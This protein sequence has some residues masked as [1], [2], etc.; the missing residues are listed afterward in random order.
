M[1]DKTISYAVREFTIPAGAT[2][3]AVR[4]AGFVTCLDASRKF[5]ISFDDGTQNDFEAGLTY[6]PK[7]GFTRLAIYNPSDSVLTVRLGLG[8]GNIADARVTISAGNTLA[9]RERNTDQLA[10][11]APISAADG[12]VTLLAPADDLRR[13]FMAVI[14]SDAGGAVYIGGDAGAVAG[15]GLPVQAGQSLTLSTGAAIYAR[16]DTGAVVNIAVALMG[17]SA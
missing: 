12:A 17:W 4:D 9:T 8:K 7:D 11:P 3:S 13:E 6:R 1:A 14:P 2:V 16:N 10:T 15:Q 5:K